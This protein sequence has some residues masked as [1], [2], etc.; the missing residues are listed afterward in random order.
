MSV[1]RCISWFSYVLLCM[2][3]L[4]VSD[5]GKWLKAD[6][7]GYLLFTH[8][9]LSEYMFSNKLYNAESWWFTVDKDIGKCLRYGV[10]CSSDQNR[11][12]M[13]CIYICVFCPSV[14]VGSAA[15]E[16]IS[17]IFHL[18]RMENDVNP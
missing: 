13:C 16:S 7:S 6:T 8:R 14:F 15:E 17:N 11:C 1:Y 18:R 4:S 3:S 2:R 5:V 10:S 12:V 9:K